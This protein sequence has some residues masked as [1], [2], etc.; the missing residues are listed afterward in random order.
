MRRR[1]FIIR[2]SSALLSGAVF[3]ALNPVESFRSDHSLESLVGKPVDLARLGAA[4]SWISPDSSG[5]IRKFWASPE[6]SGETLRLSQLSGDGPIDI[7][8]EWPEFRTVNKIVIGF[9]GNIP[10]AH[11]VTLQYWNGLSPWQGQW[12]EFEKRFLGLPADKEGNVWEYAVPARRASK[13]RLLLEVRSGIELESFSI[14]GNSY[15]KRGD[16]RIEWG[17]ARRDRSRTEKLEIYNGQILKVEAFG[18]AQLLGPLNWSSP[19]GDGLSGVT[20]NV[21][22]TW[23]MNVDRTILTVRSNQGDYSFLPGEILENQPIH[24]PDFD[25][26]LRNSVVDMGLA[27]FT[28]QNSGR[29]RV[30]NA[31]ARLPEQTFENASKAIHVRRVELSFVGVDSNNHKFG[32][33]PAGHVIV[34]GG[35]PSRGNAMNAEFGMFFDSA[36]S[37]ALFEAAGTKKHL[38]QDLAPK[39][40]ELQEGWLPIIVT[41]WSE[42]DIGF[43]RS[44]FGVLP[45]MAAD[46]D[47][48]KLRGDEPAVLISRLT[49]TNNAVVPQVAE[50]YIRPWRPAQG[51]MP[52]RGIPNDVAPGWTT[53][54]RENFV[55]VAD[56]NGERTV[57]YLD[58]HDKG[59]LSLSTNYGAV[60][61]SILVPPGKQVNMDLV[62][63]GNPLSTAD[64]PRIRG[65][66]Y[67]G[68]Q[69]ATGRYWKKL[70]AS[71]MTIEVPDQHLQ[72]LFDASLHH[73]MLAL[74]KDFKRNEHYPNVAMM[75]YG[76]IGSES[77][78]IMQALDMRGMHVRVESCLRAWLS[79]QGES[80]PEG[81]YASKEGGFYNFWP[82]YTI[83][84]GGVL[85]ALA[86]H[87]LY[88][89]D[90][91]WL[92]QNVK[93]IIDG[94]DFIIRERRRIMALEN[95]EVRP[96]W[97]GLAPAG[98]TADMRD[99]EYSFML[100][101]YFYLALKKCAIAIQAVDKKQA[102]R[103]AGEAQDFLQSIRQ[104]LKECIAISPAMRLRDNTGVPSVPSY[105]GLRGLSTDAEDSVDPDLRHG[106]GY[107]STLGPF[108]LVKCEVLEPDSSEV[109]WMLNCLE[110][111][112]FLFTPLGSRV[113][114]SC[115]STDWFNLGGF[116]KLQP[117]YVHYQ[118]AYL[119][120]DEVPNFLRGF[121]NTVCSIADPMTLTFQEELD[122]EYGEGGEPHKTHE[123]GW[124]F[125][126]FRF[127]LLMEIE[128]DLFLA[129]GTPREWL[130]HGK[131]IVVNNAPSYF[132]SLSYSIQS[133]ERD[134][135]IEAR[136]IP[137]NRHHPKTIYLR[138]RHPE[139]AAIKAVTVNGRPWTRFDAP[140][141]WIE[142]PLDMGEVTVVSTY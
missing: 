6:S 140:K 109:E 135:R 131:R 57:C 123:E 110:D 75:R 113:D 60:K 29:S 32:I 18:K 9:A 25:V 23:G 67:A 53:N 61:F 46:L 63:A 42:N 33:A 39:H 22:Y 2:G 73:F 102:M 76:S 21:L 87:Y 50:Y 59:S 44:D 78:P 85:W 19:A 84:Q 111:R 52:Y 79:T 49:I 55:T 139:K 120:R 108:H 64:A 51:Q 38:F 68:L 47:E 65:L 12:K 15:W 138:L 83:D 98:C 95:D 81:D 26:Y 100:N 126:Q 80:Q 128:D 41:K 82:V 121:F 124:F 36:G 127:M 92:S 48:A 96:A 94:C 107:D 130:Q 136:V 101:G 1:D 90:Q 10:A 3:P 34:A 97:Y 133:F 119:Q 129:R 104:V 77:S 114:L 13:I 4:R 122:E 72:S 30:C 11:M 31:V 58:T 5:A 86:E 14:Y 103:I 28:K 8:V 37:P 71:G 54:L 16:V 35:N 62:V 106:Y 69:E 7:G 24:L 17:H 137:P 88:T 43:R 45:G 125:H 93:K 56:Q 112:F 27:E 99:W 20:A 115:L 74:T 89:R 132:G 142:I 116:E 40:Q 66:D 105:V 118:D 91:Q 141:E 70:L 134:R 117:Y